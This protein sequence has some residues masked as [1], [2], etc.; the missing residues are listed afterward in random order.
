MYALQV[1]IRI[2]LA[3]QVDLLLLHWPC[4]SFEETIATYR[5][6]EEVALAGKVRRANGCILSR[7]RPAR[8][9]HSGERRIHGS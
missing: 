3:L 5:A 2:A 6:L 4:N 1:R 7:A 9:P 8:L